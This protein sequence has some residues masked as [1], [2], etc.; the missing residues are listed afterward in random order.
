M[1]RP[2][3]PKK[4]S[5]YIENSE[6]NRNKTR[7]LRLDL[8]KNA[9]S[10]LKSCRVMFGWKERKEWKSHCSKKIPPPSAFKRWFS[11]EGNLGKYKYHALCSFPK[12]QE[13]GFPKGCTVEKRGCNGL[14]FKARCQDAKTGKLHGKKERSV[15]LKLNH[16]PK[17]EG[18]GA[19]HKKASLLV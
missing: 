18:L 14:R 13:S 3:V 19:L 2:A 7:W 10:P 17:N 8:P 9:H 5:I 12:I 6:K 1:E 11:Q 16:S 4:K 15:I